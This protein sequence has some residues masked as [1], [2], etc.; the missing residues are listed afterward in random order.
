M[1]KFEQMIFDSMA[2]SIEKKVLPQ[3]KEFLAQ[4]SFE[5]KE[6][7]TEEDLCKLLDVSSSTTRRFRASGLPSAKIGGRWYYKKVDI[8]KWVEDKKW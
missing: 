8:D 5:K 6:L 7:L 1:K 2:E 4:R 3:I